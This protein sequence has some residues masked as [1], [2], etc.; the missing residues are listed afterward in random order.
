VEVEVNGLMTYDR[1]V[2]KIPAEKLRELH[3]KL[4]DPSLVPMKASSAFMK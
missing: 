3:K 4:Y 1:K 2:I